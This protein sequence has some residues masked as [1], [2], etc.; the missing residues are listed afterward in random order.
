MGMYRGYVEL[1]KGLEKVNRDGLWNISRKV[2]C[3]EQGS[4]VV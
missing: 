4:N 1:T 3:G 2:G